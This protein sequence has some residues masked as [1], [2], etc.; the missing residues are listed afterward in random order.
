MLKAVFG[1]LVFGAPAQVRQAERM[2]EVLPL[3]AF[4]E[5]RALAGAYV[6]VMISYEA[7]PVFDSA[8]T[9]H[10]ATE[11]PLAW[12]AVFPTASELD[13]RERGQFVASDWQ[14]RVSKTEYERA[15]GRI[16]EL[17]A[18]GDTYQV[19]YSF[20]LTSTFSGDA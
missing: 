13:E 17:I 7:S 10:R 3:L 12:A 9:V 11:F 4:A 1:S 15:V 16:R 2:D 6:V 19:N 5:A 20:P 8:L 14:P 18:A